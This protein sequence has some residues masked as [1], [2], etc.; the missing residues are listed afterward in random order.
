MV[1]LDVHVVGVDDELDGVEPDRP[2]HCSALVEAVDHVV[3][4]PVQRL[5]EDLDALGGGMLGEL[6]EGLDEDLDV[7][8]LRAAAGERWKL[9]RASVG[10]RRDD[11]DAAE[12]GDHRQLCLQV[13]HGVAT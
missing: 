12:L 1:L 8:L 6:G 10:R 2:A 9:A 4:V 7:L 5:E 11:T 13:G 3:L